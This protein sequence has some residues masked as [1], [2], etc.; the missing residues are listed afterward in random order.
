M[1]SRLSV[2]L[3]SHRSH[4]MRLAS[5]GR[6]KA[7]PCARSSNALRACPRRHWHERRAVALH[8]LVHLA[9]E[10][11]NRAEASRASNYLPPVEVERLLAASTDRAVARHSAMSRLRAR[12]PTLVELPLD[13]SSNASGP[14][15][16]SAWIKP[17]R[18][19]MDTVPP[20]KIVRAS[21]MV[22]TDRSISANECR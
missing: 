16:L 2:S 11:R 7:L 5:H 21:T 20:N 8:V 13:D 12:R 3:A 19:E 22:P 9:V 6:A 1:P 14:C 17:M 18:L 10:P 15:A 4:L